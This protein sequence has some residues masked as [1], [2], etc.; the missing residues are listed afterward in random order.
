MSL[1]LGA[2]A[3]VRAEEGAWKGAGEGAEK[4][5]GAGEDAGGGQGQEEGD[6]I[7]QAERVILG[8][9]GVILRGEITI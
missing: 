9:V 3:A 1:F 6:V 5:A 4:G 2:A 7:E 8:W